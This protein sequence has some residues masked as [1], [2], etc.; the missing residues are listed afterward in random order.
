M[1]IAE[2]QEYICD[3]QKFAKKN[4]L[5][6]TKQYLKLL[7]NPCRDAKII[8]VAG[9]NGKGSVCNYLRM[10]LQEHGYRTAMFVSPHLVDMRERMLLDGEMVSSE[11]FMEAFVRVQ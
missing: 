5:E 8:H 10:L 4:T 7:G 3:I 9:T 11:Q 6:H 2:A 1:N